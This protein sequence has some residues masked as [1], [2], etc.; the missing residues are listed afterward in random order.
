M[1]KNRRV[2]G[3]FDSEEVV[4]ERRIAEQLAGVMERKYSLKIKSLVIS[5]TLRESLSEREQLFERE[6]EISRLLVKPF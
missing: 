3:R 6:P 5:R 4:S 1:E 2:E